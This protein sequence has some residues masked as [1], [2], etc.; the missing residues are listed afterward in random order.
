VNE[1]YEL[2]RRA[3]RILEAKLATGLKE[4]LHIFGAIQETS[5]AHARVDLVAEM[6]S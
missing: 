6:T 2:T 5:A 4:T 1:L 3:G